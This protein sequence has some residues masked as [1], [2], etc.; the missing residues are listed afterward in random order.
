M[1]DYEDTLFTHVKILDGNQ[2][3]SPDVAVANWQEAKERLVKS[4]DKK[5]IESKF[6]IWDGLNAIKKLKSQFAVAKTK[7]RVT[8]SKNPQ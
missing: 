5:E 4:R 7:N 8:C 1:P 6:A 2:V 3:E